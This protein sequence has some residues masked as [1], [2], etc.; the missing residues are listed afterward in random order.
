MAGFRF[1]P[2]SFLHS[3]LFLKKNGLPWALIDSSWKNVAQES[4]GYSDSPGRMFYTCFV[5]LW[6]S[7]KLS[8]IFWDRLGWELFM[9]WS[10]GKPDYRE[11]PASLLWES[12]WE[13]CHTTRPNPSLVLGCSEQTL[14][15]RESGDG[16][17]AVRIERIREQGGGTCT[18]T[19]AQ[20]FFRSHMFLKLKIWLVYK[21][22][23]RR[24]R[25]V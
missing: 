9:Q 12:G 20:F 11:N 7:Q 17:Q 8:R 16:C 13:L 6:E 19:Q 1:C 4:Q 10:K 5:F 14:P 2:F 15:E 23:I 3:L 21:N 18:W 22:D 24:N 25:G